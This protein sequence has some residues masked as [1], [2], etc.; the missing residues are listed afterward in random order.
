DVP[1]LFTAVLQMDE[2]EIRYQL[3]MIGFRA[4]HHLTTMAMLPWVVAEICRSSKKDPG[5]GPHHAARGSPSCSNKTVLLCV[6]A[7]WVRCVSVPA[8]RRLWD[9]LTHTVLFEC[10]PHQV[11]KLIHNSQEPSVFACLVKDSLKCA[12]Y[13]FQ[14][15]DSTKRV[16]ACCSSY[17]LSPVRN[18]RTMVAMMSD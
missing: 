5:A 18:V 15:L 13:V 7:S 4:V 12:C 11:T 8:E 14:D 9:P 3:T 1:Y 6:S 2:E 16:S 10:R 17:A